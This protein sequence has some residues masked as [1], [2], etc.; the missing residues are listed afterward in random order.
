MLVTGYVLYRPST[1]I[2]YFDKKFYLYI[3]FN[4]TFI[5]SHG[6]RIVAFCILYI[7]AYCVNQK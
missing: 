5:W 1:A 6:I 3:T 7:G 4:H 2:K